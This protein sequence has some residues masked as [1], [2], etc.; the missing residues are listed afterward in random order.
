MQVLLCLSVSAALQQACVRLIP[1]FNSRIAHR[2]LQPGA[3]LHVCLFV[4]KPPMQL[5]QYWAQ[6]AGCHTCIPANGMIPVGNTGDEEPCRWQA[7]IEAHGQRGMTVGCHQVKANKCNLFFSA[8]E[9]AG[10]AGFHCAPLC[11]ILPAAQ[12][13]EA[14]AGLWR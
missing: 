13:F 4:D 14:A 11:R 9:A 6:T 7:A 3:T 12:G 5:V 8:T 10:A 1:A 2:H